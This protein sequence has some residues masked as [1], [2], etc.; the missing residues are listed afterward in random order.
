[1]CVLWES[2]IHVTLCAFLVSCSHISPFPYIFYTT[3]FPASALQSLLLPFP[4]FGHTNM[5]WIQS[6]LFHFKNHKC[7]Y[8]FHYYY[9]CALHAKP[10]VAPVGLWNY[11]N[12]LSAA[13]LVSSFMLQYWWEC[14]LSRSFWILTFSCNIGYPM[15]N[16]L[17]TN[18]NNAFEIHRPS[19]KM[20]MRRST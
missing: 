4:L 17:W 2:F 9:K 10:S 19:T 8:Y 6:E 16:L 5:N 1:M 12:I 7:Y 14:F 13:F 15:W 18:I 20:G 3:L 11:N